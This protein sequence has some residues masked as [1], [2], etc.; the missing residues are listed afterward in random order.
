MLILLQPTLVK[1]DQIEVGVDV[2]AAITT[3]FFQ[4]MHKPGFL[5]GSVWMTVNHTLIPFFD[6]LF[7]MLGPVFLYP[8]QN[9]FIVLQPIDRFLELVGIELQKAK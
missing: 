5:R 4:E 1:F 3:C 2:F 6:R 9:G 7:G 8:I